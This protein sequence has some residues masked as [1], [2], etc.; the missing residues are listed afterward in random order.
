MLISGVSL[1]KHAPTYPKRPNS[2]DV[3]A[4]HA[5]FVASQV[6]LDHFSDLAPVRDKEGAC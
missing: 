6:D 3:R 2:H 5:S 4:I 1:N